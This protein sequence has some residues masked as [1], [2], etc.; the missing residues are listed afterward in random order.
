MIK[1]TKIEGVIFY[2]LVVLIILSILG[3]VFFIKAC[4]KII[5]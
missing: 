3:S 2:V 5:L 4:C 1:N